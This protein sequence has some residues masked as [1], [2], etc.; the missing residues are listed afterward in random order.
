MSKELI[1]L[2]DNF[3]P[4]GEGNERPTF[5][6]R[7][8]FVLKAYNIG[9]SGEY[10][11]LIVRNNNIFLEALLFKIDIKIEIGAIISFLYRPISSIF[12]GEEKI[13]LMIQQIIN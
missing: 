8:M 7:D 2:L 10:Q 11:K 4:Y 5:L 3:E 6:A 12:K 1:I 9:K 13:Q